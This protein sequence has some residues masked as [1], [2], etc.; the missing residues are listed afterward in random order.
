MNLLFWVR[1]ATGFAVTT[2]GL[3]LTWWQISKGPMANT[4]AD[5]WFLANIAPAMLALA[6]FQRGAMQ[7][8][9]LQSAMQGAATQAPFVFIT[10]S[11]KLIWLDELLALMKEFVGC[12]W[13]NTSSASAI[14]GSAKQVGR[15]KCSS[16]LSKQN[17][18]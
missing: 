18:A 5:S 6:G 10:G 9:N 7:L 13:H 3:A 15:A 8:H 14:L 2:E 17:A 11:S 1:F 4:R 16:C 12:R